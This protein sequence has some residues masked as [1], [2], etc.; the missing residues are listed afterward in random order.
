MKNKANLLVLVF[1]TVVL[2]I[3]AAVVQAAEVNMTGT[4]NVSVD[5]P[6]GKG[7]P[8]F[9]LEQKGDQLTGTYTGALGEAKVKGNIKGNDFQLSFNANGADITYSGKVEGNKISGAVD[10]GTFGKGTFTGEKKLSIQ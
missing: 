1:F 6:M 10:L 8:V 9:V 3:G 7:T 5:S 2:I 4:R